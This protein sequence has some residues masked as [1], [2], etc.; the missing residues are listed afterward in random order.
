[1]SFNFNFNEKFRFGNFQKGLSQEAFNLLDANKD[2]KITKDEENLFD[3]KIQQKYGRTDYAQSKNIFETNIADY[4]P[5]WITDETEREAYALAISGRE[6]QGWGITNDGA[7]SADEN[8]LLLE[9][10]EMNKIA[11]DFIKENPL[12]VFGTFGGAISQINHLLNSFVM[13]NKDRTTNIEKLS[14]EFKSQLQNLTTQD[15][16]SYKLNSL[17]WGFKDDILESQ[18]DFSKTMANL[19]GVISKK[20]ARI[21]HHITTDLLMSRALQGEN[22]MGILDNLIDNTFDSTQKEELVKLATQIQELVNQRFL[23]TPAE[24][25]SELHQLASAIAMTISLENFSDNFADNIAHYN[26]NSASVYK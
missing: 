18:L 25:Y 26:Q 16:A 11:N 7:L 17:S 20:E 2:G 4:V 23:K 19:D 13:Q 5:Y 8:K 9:I 21:I 15:I 1:M 10:Q 6:N 3:Q 12:F 14:D 24:F 22:V